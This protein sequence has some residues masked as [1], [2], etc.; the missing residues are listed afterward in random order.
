MKAL[1]WEAPNRMALR[2][3]P[4]P[5]IQP[6]QVLVQVAFAGICGSEL[7][8]YLG[9]NAL[10]VPPLVMGHEF[11]GTIVEIGA[12]ARES[13]PHLVPGQRVTAFPFSYCGSCEF[14]QSG[15]HQLCV[16]RRLVGAHQPG[17]F[18]EYVAVRANQIFDLPEGVRLRD[19]ALA[20][21]AACAVRIASLAGDVRGQ[22]CLVL[23]AGPM[24]LLALQAL[25]LAGAAQLWVADL[26]PHRLRMA[27]DLGAT[28]LDPR[29]TD[30]V[31]VVRRET[32]GRGVGVA[33]DA[34][35]TAQTRQQCIAA[36]ASVGKVI[37]SGLHEE[38][39]IVPVADVIRREI[40]LRGSF[41]YSLADF[42]SALEWLEQGAVRLD[43]W[44]VEVPLERGGE[45][46]EA[47][48]QPQKDVA[49][50][51]LVP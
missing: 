47:L 13:H 31:E 51:L 30:V 8:G 25:A 42:A 12:R 9:H 6:D 7:S 24:G 40:T 37:L 17:A 38:S 11:T 41:S 45:W 23:G 20:E 49:K 35:G 36:T 44:I 43:P 21:P 48:L 34:V 28:A 19:G 1:V 16:S 27:G 50:V 32:K 2:E 14:C 4:R 5:A 26:D 29:S 33:V 3:Q 10:R 46:F 15:L 39:S 18:A 22:G